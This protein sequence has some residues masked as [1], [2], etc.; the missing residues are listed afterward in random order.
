MCLQ[1]VEGYHAFGVGAATPR[2]SIGQMPQGGGAAS[3]QLPSR[4]ES[5]RSMP[6][7]RDCVNKRDNGPNPRIAILHCAIVCS[8]RA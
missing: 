4:G 5:Y 6:A 3:C 7:R 8:L 2:F 1:N